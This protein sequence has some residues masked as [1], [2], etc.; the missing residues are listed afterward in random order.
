LAATEVAT[1]IFRSPESSMARRRRVAASIRSKVSVRVG[2]YICPASVSIRRRLKR[3]KSWI[4]KASS[5]V[6]T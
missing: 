4:C 1:L 5:R 6:F 3:R 2:R